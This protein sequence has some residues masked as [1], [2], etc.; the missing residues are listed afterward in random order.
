MH[1]AFINLRVL[2]VIDIL[3]VAFL[4]YQLYMIIRG[5]VAINIFVGIALLYMAW[6]VVRALNME[7][8]STILGQFMGVGVIALLIVFQQEVRRFFLTIGTRSQSRADKTLGGLFASRG[9]GTSEK[10]LNHVITACKNMAN[11]RTGALIVLGQT[12]NMESIIQTG[13]VINSLISSRLIESVFTNNSPLHDGAVII[14]GETIRAARCVLPVS[15]S[16]NLPPNLGLRHR[17]GL[18]MSENSDAYIVIVSEETGNISMAHKSRLHVDISIDQLA[19][20]LKGK[21]KV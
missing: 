19:D 8:L 7:L 12:S 20:M 14:E 4:L 3:L 15:E 16:T 11:R 13:D 9:D 10:G 5:T 2:D 21:S 17:S 18:G 6:L 1:L